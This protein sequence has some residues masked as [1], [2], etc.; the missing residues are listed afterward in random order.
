M[1]EPEAGSDLAALRTIAT[2]GEEN[3]EIKGY[4]LNGNKHVFIHL[5]SPLYP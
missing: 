1:S 4:K 5:I 2:P 3:G